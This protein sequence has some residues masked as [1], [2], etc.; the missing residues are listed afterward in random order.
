VLVALGLVLAPVALP[1]TPRRTA[2]ALRAVNPELGE[3]VGWEQ[4]ATQARALHVRHPH[5]GIL[6][7]NYSEA[8]G[9]ELLAPDLPQ[10]ASGHNSYWDWGPPAGDPDEVIVFAPDRAPLDAAFARVRRIATVASP[11][12][13]HNRED[14]TPIWLA[15]GRR[16]PWSELWPRF[17][18]V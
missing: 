10:P 16:A 15:S 6:T 11:D 14:G 7:T 18:R 1:L 5:A 2:D 3:M 13:V 17:R 8:G 4:L 12:G 9:I